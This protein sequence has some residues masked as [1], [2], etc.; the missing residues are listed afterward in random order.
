MERLST[1]LL[2]GG[3]ATFLIAFVLMGLAPILTL[4]SIPMKSVE[5]IAQDIPLE[6]HLLAEEYP[7]EF[8]EHFGE[9]NPVSFADAL[10][11]GKR[12]YIQE[13]CWHCHSQYIRPVSNEDLRFGPVS[14]P[15]EYKNEMNLP[16][17]FGTRRVGPDLIRQSGVHSNDWHM[18]HFYHPPNV[19]PASVMPSYSWFF[20]ENKRP[21]KRGLAI[22][23]YVQ[24]LGSWIKETPESIYNVE[25][26]T[27]KLTANAS[28]AGMAAPV[29]EP[30][31]DTSGESAGDEASF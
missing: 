11:V 22:T 31:S 12:V 27:P 20:D 28:D 16:H 17:L 7:E 23:A 2:V 6:F 4:G 5:E 1:I 24:W 3:L 18:A 19:I 9:V 30:S 29:T 8:K 10:R 21:N 26:I 13:A 15:E 25:A 14:T